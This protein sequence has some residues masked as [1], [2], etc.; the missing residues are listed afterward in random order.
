M[1]SIIVSLTFLFLFF[2]ATAQKSRDMLYQFPAKDLSNY[3]VAADAL[4]NKIISHQYAGV[5]RKQLE[6]FAELIAKDKEDFFLKGNVYV[7]WDK[8]EQY[9]NKIMQKILPDSLKG[10]PDIHV[11]PTR[12]TEINACAMFDGSI[13]FNIGLFA[14]VTNEA[15][16]AIILGHEL[17]HYL[18]KDGLYGYIRGTKIRRKEIKANGINDKLKYAFENMRYSRAQETR[19]D[20]IGFI[21]AKKAGYDLYYGI[22]NFKRFQEEE[23]AE[24]VKLAQSRVVYPPKAEGQLSR[25]DIIKLLRTHPEN[26]DRIEKLNTFILNDAT[27]PKQKFIISESDFRELQEREAAKN[28]GAAP[29]SRE[30][31][32]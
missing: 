19:A 21:L 3:N 24:D 12:I 32:N 31:K 6:S 15:S 17:G 10:N 16:I 1:R 7:G 22:D 28:A 26:S 23:K 18:M 11:Y 20:S 8:M 30:T 14:N 4:Y 2:G 29:A 9:L 5:K 25:S 13:Y 27:G